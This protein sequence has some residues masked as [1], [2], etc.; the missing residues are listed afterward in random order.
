MIFGK[1][2]YFPLFFC[3]GHSALLAFFPGAPQLWGKLGFLRRYTQDKFSPRN[4]TPTIGADVVTKEVYKDGLKVRL[5]V[6]DTS[7]PRFLIA[8]RLVYNTVWEPF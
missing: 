6:W 7:I 2:R 4:T 5:E 1:T 8:V 3:T